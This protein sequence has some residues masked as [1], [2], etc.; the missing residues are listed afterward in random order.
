[1]TRTISGPLRSVCLASIAC[2]APAQMTEV[3]LHS[4]ARGPN[5]HAP[6]SGVVRDS[7]GNLYG[8]TDFANGSYGV[9]YKLDTSRHLT[10][11]NRFTGLPG[12]SQPNG[13]IR[14]ADG[15]LYGTTFLGGTYNFGV[16]FSVD[17]SG[18]EQV[19]YEFT[20]H[21]DGKGPLGP[22]VR[23]STGALYGGAVGGGQFGGGAVFKLD[24][25]GNET[26]LYSFTGGADGSGPH[27]G[28]IRDSEGN[29]YGTTYRGGSS[30]YGVV[31]KV[32]A[33][34][35]E[36][37]LHSF[38]GGA[39][40]YLPYAGVIRD[41]AGNLYGTAWGG[42]SRMCACGVV[43]KVDAS[44]KFKVLHQFTG[45]PND[46]AYPLAGV[47]R[48]SAG[49]L[50]GTTTA[51]GSGVGTCG[52]CGVVYMID[53]LGNAALL[54]SFSGYPDGNYPAASLVRD[55]A[56][57]LYGTTQ[58]GGEYGYGTVFQLKP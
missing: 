39:D 5:G 20:G 17:A 25:A 26:V 44:G 23:D 9:V 47:I 31:F 4:F 8:A 40:G 16:V 6:R 41:P 46:G 29:F 22:L 2:V 27:G 49:N 10:I 51:G 24:P 28:V 55:S 57:N 52:G 14:D 54:H 58:N 38:T 1:M 53:A 43:Y 13:L 42:G 48:D 15:V 3:V 19:L 12:G 32:D 18:G 45:H 21:A 30:G 35:N 34:G 7:A 11:L 37:V 36:T 56:G 50:Y 33:S